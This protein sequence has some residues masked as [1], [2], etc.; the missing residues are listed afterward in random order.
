MRRAIPRIA[1][2]VSGTHGEDIALARRIA[3]GE[4]GALEELYGRHR[5]A[6]FGYLLGLAPDRE[7]AEE[8]LQDTL[9]AVWR[10][11]GSYE[12]RS[13][14]R[15]WLFGVARGQAHNTLRRRR[16]SLADPSELEHLAS[17]EPEP[18]A[19]AL[20]RL[21]RAEL[22]AGIHR[23]TPEHRQVVVLVLVEGLSYKEVARELGVPM[24]TV[25]SRLSNARRALK[26]MLR[27]DEGVGR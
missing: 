6:L 4:R 7:T 14:L 26:G 11:A 12:G 23:L 21:T 5:I 19:L 13:P 24:G 16:F 18:E 2:A 9:V 25:R 15:T 27:V 17:E 3:S 10:S 1:G 22:E 8:I 20:A